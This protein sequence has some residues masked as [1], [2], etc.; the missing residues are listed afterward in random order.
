MVKFHLI[1]WY[2]RKDLSEETANAIMNYTLY[3]NTVLLF[4]F[5]F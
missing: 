4:S 3:L 5:V 2:I 1:H